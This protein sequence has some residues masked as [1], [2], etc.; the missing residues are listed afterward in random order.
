MAE[1]Q[2]NLAEVPVAR[3][4]GRVDG[5]TAATKGDNARYM[6]KLPWKRKAANLS[7]PSMK[8]LDEL[9]ITVIDKPDEYII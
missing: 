7:K 4:I 5:P 8:V 2:E 6:V 1:S 9:G 3:V